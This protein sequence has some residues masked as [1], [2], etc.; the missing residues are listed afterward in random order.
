V[1]ARIIL[2]GVRAYQVML[3]PLFSGSC[4]YVPSCSQYMAEAIQRHGARR[5][6]WLGL[7]RLGRCH[8]FGSSGFDPVPD[9]GSDFPASQATSEKITPEV[10]SVR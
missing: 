1:A 7:C 5:G 10:F 9:S 6:S 4:R 8:P 2:A 3:S